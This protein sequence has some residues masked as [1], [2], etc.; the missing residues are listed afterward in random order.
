MVPDDEL[1]VCPEEE[2]D[3]F[4]I[5]PQGRSF[6]TF[7]CRELAY[8]ERLIAFPARRDIYGSRYRHAGLDATGKHARYLND[9]ANL[10]RNQ[11][12]SLITLIPCI[13][14]AQ[15]RLFFNFFFL[16]LSL[17]QLVKMFEVG[18]WYTYFG[19]LIFVLLI[20]I[21]KESVDDFKRCLRDREV[22][23]E[24]FHRLRVNGPNHGTLEEICSRDIRVGDLIQIN[25]NQ[26]IPA[27]MLLLRTSDNSNQ[28]YVRTDQL[29]GETDWKLRKPPIPTQSLTLEQL[30][31]CDALVRAECPKKDIYEFTGRITLQSG[32]SAENMTPSS[33]NHGGVLKDGLRLENTLWANCVVT[34]GPVI[35]L[36]LYT[37]KETRATLNT[38]RA[39]TKYGKLD[40]EVDW[41]AKLCFSVLIMCCFGLTIG[42]GVHW[43]VYDV[44]TWYRFVVLLSYIIPISLRVNL[45]MAKLLYT[46]RIQCD[47]V[48]VDT[49]M[50]NTSIPEEL[51]RVDYV[52][53]DKTGTLTKN[54]MIFKK[55][56]VP[57]GEFGEDDI[58]RLRRFSKNMMET[59]TAASLSDPAGKKQMRTEECVFNATL[60]LGLCHN[61]TPI[62]DDCGNWDLQAASPDEV[63]LVKFSAEAGLKLI[64][65]DDHSITLEVIN[66]QLGFDVLACFPFTST[67]K[68]MGILVRDRRNGELTFYLKG[69]DVVMLERVSKKGSSWLQEEVENYARSGLRTLVVARKKIT[70]QEYIDWKKKYDQAKTAMKDRD[71]KIQ[72]VVDILETKMELLALTGV[73]DKLQDNVQETLESLRHAGIKI[74]MLTGDKVETAI[75]I[76]IST[77]LKARHHLLFVL[78]ENSGVDNAER[79]IQKLGDLANGRLSETVIVIDGKVLGWLLLENNVKEFIG[80][81]SNAPAV[82][83]CRCSPTQKADVV[84]AIKKYTGKCTAAIGDGGNDV[85]MIQAAHVGVGIVGKEGKQAS[86]SADVSVL[87]FSTIRRLLLWHGRNAYQASARL[88]SFVIHRGLII[89]FIQVI[90]SSVFYFVAVPLFQG[91]LMVGYSTVFTM[92]PVFALCLD[93]ELPEHTVFMYP[94]LYQSLRLEKR[95]SS[96]KF[97]QCVWKS[98]YQ[99]A[100]IMLLSS[101]FFEAPAWLNIVAI[102][103]SALILSELLN[104]AS[105]VH[106]W[107]PLMIMAELLSLYVYVYAVLILRSYFDLDFVMSLV[108]VKNLAIVVALSWVPIH[109]MKVMRKCISPLQHQKL[110]GD[111]SEDAKPSSSSA[112]SAITASGGLSLTASGGLSLGL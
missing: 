86:L 81:A 60:A 104:V 4:E 57:T 71:A 82:V 38:S 109:F 2:Q 20:S 1:N 23:G 78:D 54:E 40:V 80:I 63:A 112:P 26:R 48:I 107:H 94:E 30:A 51:G 98:I 91:M 25:S 67:T 79:A 73:E 100:T 97:L 36:V 27:D 32:C 64:E 96:K 5:V 14:Y 72:R 88:A 70:E 108:F 19:P 41:Y 59:T 77:A 8:A 87:Q 69:A 84:N 110:L 17:S 83:C 99:A 68:R 35:G 39:Q 92:F 56:R 106:N 34:K 65:R 61:V 111:K 7:R 62:I 47:A 15:F 95:L 89:S 11:R 46:M 44:I 90:F 13:L 76:A 55:I 58:K 75:C 31:S 74:W 22:N 43:T 33:R 10:V 105:E 50:R 45:D 3:D 12:Y 9:G 21:I 24:K 66:T 29:D 93:Y 53:S 37:G 6:V 16:V 52:L 85:S 101:F 102:T 103:F 42:N 49:I 18:P 28:T